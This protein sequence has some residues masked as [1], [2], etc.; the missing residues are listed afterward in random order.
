MEEEK[1]VFAEAKDKVEALK[2]WGGITPGKFVFATPQVYKDAYPDDRSKWPKFKFKPYDGLEFNEDIDNADIYTIVDVLDK[3]GK[4]VL[5]ANGKPKRKPETK[6]GA[7]RVHAIKQG[8]KDW[9]DFRDEDGKG[10]I[11]PCPKDANGS[12]TDEAIR[13]L[14]SKVQNWVMDTIGS[15]DEVSKEESDGLKF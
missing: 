15:L 11:I 5:D 6:T 2:G 13:A 12:I 1:K 14:P 3:D 10:E 7:Y 8:L 9:A 4:P